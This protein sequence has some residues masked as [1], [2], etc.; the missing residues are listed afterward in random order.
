[1]QF[2]ALSANCAFIRTAISLTQS[3]STYCGDILPLSNCV[4]S[5]GKMEP[6]QHNILGP[7]PFEYAGAAG[8][9]PAQNWHYY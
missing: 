3:L 4:G 6:T 2:G 1:M 8:A 5:S 9:N 7:S